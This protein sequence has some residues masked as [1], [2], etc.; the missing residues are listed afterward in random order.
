MYILVILNAHSMQQGVNLHAQYALVEL[1]YMGPRKH[2]KEEKRK[3][4]A[5]TYENPSIARSGFR[6]LENCLL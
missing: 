5:L 2:S 4:K 1:N 3:R 6:V